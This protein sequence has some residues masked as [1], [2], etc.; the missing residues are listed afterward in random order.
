MIALAAGVQGNHA[1]EMIKALLS[2]MDTTA[3]ILA[4]QCL[5]TAVTVPVQI[6][7]ETRGR[8]RKLL[9]PNDLTSANEMMSAG[10][11]AGPLLMDCLKEDLDFV[12]FA[13]TILALGMIRYAP[14]I[15]AIAKF[16]G[17]EHSNLAV[18][19]LVR[20]FEGIPSAVRVLEEVAPSLGIDE[21]QRMKSY[22]RASHPM[23]VS[24]TLDKL[25][26]A[27]SRAKPASKPQKRTAAKRSSKGSVAD[28]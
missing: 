17:T 4:A 15:P 27:K 10:I 19:M 16:I 25:I 12:A 28:H 24:G 21:L 6:R 18:H 2:K 7:E 9:P 23:L 26:K 1:G 8:L 11:I 3:L 13:Y 22:M 20:S 14:A 5:E